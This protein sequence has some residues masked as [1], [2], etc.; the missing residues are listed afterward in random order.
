[1][2]GAGVIRLVRTLRLISAEANWRLSLTPQISEQGPAHVWAPFFEKIPPKI[3][4]PCYFAATNSDEKFQ[5]KKLTM[6]NWI[7]YSMILLTRISPRLLL[8]RPDRLTLFS[9]F[10]FFYLSICSILYFFYLDWL[11]FILFCIFHFLNLVDRIFHS[12]LTQFYIFS[13]NIFSIY[14]LSID[15][16]LYILIIFFLIHSIF[17]TLI[18]FLSI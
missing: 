16:I 5:V 11:K 7:F 15:S 13:F 1:M 9:I 4:N 10:A 14:S 2:N 8:S 6:R 12:W 17:Y 18:I 3:H